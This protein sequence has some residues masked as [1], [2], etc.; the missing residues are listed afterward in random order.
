MAGKLLGGVAVSLL[1]IGLYLAIG[2]VLLASFSLFGLFDPWLI[3]VL[4]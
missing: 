1:T 4:R 3:V 2:L